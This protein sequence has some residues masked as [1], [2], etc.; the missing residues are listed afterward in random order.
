MASLNSLYLY[1]VTTTD[2]FSPENGYSSPYP[3]SSTISQLESS[4]ISNPALLAIS[5]AGKQIAFGFSLWGA[6]QRNAC[7]FAFSSALHTYAPVSLQAAI[8]SS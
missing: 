6:V 8:I 7:N 5:G 2:S 3:V 1:A 4:G